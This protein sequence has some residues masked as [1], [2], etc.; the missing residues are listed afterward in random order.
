MVA[1]KREFAFPFPAPV[2]LELPEEYTDLRE[3]DPVIGVSLPTGDRAWLVTRYEDVRQIFADPRFSRSAAARSG[4]PRCNRV[5]PGPDFMVSKDPPEHMRLRRLVAPA[6][7]GQR[8]ESMRPSIERLAEALLDTME[9][10]GPP[11]DLVA[12][13]ALPLSL[14][15]ICD[16]LGIPQAD[17]KQFRTWS[18]V[19][20]SKTEE[21]P[22]DDVRKALTRFELYFAG[23][24][25][26]KRC[27]PTDDLLGILITARDQQDKL[28]EEELISMGVTL[29]VG[30]FETVSTQ[31]ANSV[32]ILLRNPDQLTRLRRDPGLVSNGVEELLRYI[33]RRADG[34]A[35]RVA[36]E[37][38]ELCGV[39]VQAGEAVIPAIGSANRDGRHFTDADRLDLTRSD[40]SHLAFA[41]GSHYCLGAPLARLEL[42]VTL[43]ALLRRFR[44]L[45]LAV[46]EQELAWRSSAMV[47]SPGVLPVTW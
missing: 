24:I 20:M 25:A 19:L 18:D 26:D 21:F 17:R 47:L 1:E 12:R 4:A 2:P 8:I 6:F 27:R 23:L 28:T 22:V 29:L 43:G 38:A 34:G 30:G 31:I 15:V 10:I 3:A 5:G 32:V 41:F 11:V 16:L 42:Q 33:P 9:E 40:K 36:L 14:T 46:P 13:L 44:E 39:R 35:I 7:T 37:D 45:R